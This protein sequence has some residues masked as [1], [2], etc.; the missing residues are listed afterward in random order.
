MTIELYFIINALFY[1][2]EYLSELF[3]S[4]EED[5]FFSFIPGRVNQYIYTSVV[6]G[7]ISYFMSYFFIEENKIKRIFVRNK[8]EEV[9]MKYE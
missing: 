2:E 6:S 5:N 9:K 1:N 7:I 3:K 4:N 8:R